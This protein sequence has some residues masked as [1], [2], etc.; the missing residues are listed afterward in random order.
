MT[1]LKLWAKAFIL[2]MNIYQNKQA[3]DKSIYPG[4]HTQ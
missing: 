3:H 2:Y 4:K 1:L